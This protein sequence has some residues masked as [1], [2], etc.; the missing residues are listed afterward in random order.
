MRMMSN[1]NMKRKS[2]FVSKAHLEPGDRLD[3]LEVPDPMIHF[4]AKPG[5][6]HHFCL[7]HHHYHK[8]DGDHHPHLRMVFVAGSEMGTSGGNSRVSLQFITFK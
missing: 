6:D 1:E 4:V 3:V 7:Q 8:E 5:H 2:V